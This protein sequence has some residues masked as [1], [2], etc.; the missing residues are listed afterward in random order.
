MV[1]GAFDLGVR[2]LKYLTQ[3]PYALSLL[4]SNTQAPRNRFCAF[5]KANAEC[6]CVAQTLIQNALP[7]LGL[8]LIFS[9]TKHEYHMLSTSLA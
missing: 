1:G 7:H 9:K 4:A 3:L 8:L 6:S 5:T 2:F